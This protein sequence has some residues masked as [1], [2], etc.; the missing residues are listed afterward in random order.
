MIAQILTDQRRCETVLDDP[1]RGEPA[2]HWRSLPN[3]G[4]AVIAMDP[5]PG[6]ALRRLVLACHWT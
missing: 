1:E 6:S 4:Q 5:D 3:A 2:L